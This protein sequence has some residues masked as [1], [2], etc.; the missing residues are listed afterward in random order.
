MGGEAAIIRV[1]LRTISEIEA[2]TR[3]IRVERARQSFD[4]FATCPGLPKFS[5]TLTNHGAAAVLCWTSAKL[6]R[7]FGLASGAP[8]RRAARGG[9][10]GRRRRCP[11]AS[12]SLPAHLIVRLRRV[13][14]EALSYS[15]VARPPRPRTWR[16]RP[17]GSARPAGGEGEYPEDPIPSAPRLHPGCRGAEP[18][19]PERFPFCTVSVE[20]G[21]SLGTTSMREVQSSFTSMSYLTLCS[22]MPLPAWR[23]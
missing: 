6:F 19:H 18:F 22:G 9:R 11:V 20:L 23:R 17:R 2:L 5:R 21:S 7:R 14:G 12:R 8:S 4:A 16:R 13:E 3:R 1:A 10:A 15:L